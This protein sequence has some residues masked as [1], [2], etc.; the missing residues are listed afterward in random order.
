[1]FRNK[2]KIQATLTFQ[3]ATLLYRSFKIEKIGG[4]SPTFLGY[5]PLFEMHPKIA[6]NQ[7]YCNLLNFKQ[8][9]A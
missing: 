4:H 2:F 6:K 3:K 8:F 9:K 7:C 5:S 1:M